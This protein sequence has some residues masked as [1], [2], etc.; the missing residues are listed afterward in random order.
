MAVPSSTVR[1]TVVVC[2][3]AIPSSSAVT[4][5]LWAPPPS[6]TS[7]ELMDSSIPVDSKS[8]STTVTT[9]SSAPTLVY[10]PPFAVWVNVTS[11]S[12]ASLSCTA[13]TFTV[14]G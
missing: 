4:V 8:S 2:P 7:W 5:R 11:S 12:S 14:W 1:V 10:P 9:T 6:R 3:L 13:V